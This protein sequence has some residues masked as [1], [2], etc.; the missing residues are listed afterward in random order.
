MIA[1]ELKQTLLAALDR[2][3]GDDLERAHSMFKNCTQK[4]MTD[5]Y[6][7]NGE[8]RRQILNRYKAHADCVERAITYVRSI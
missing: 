5:P 3:R 4:Q 8:T 7:Y 2:Y 6:G 1:P